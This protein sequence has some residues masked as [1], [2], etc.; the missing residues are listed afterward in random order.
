M[1]LVVDDDKNIRLSLK[2]ILERNDY[3]VAL[4]EGPKEAMQIVRNTPAVELVLM[5]MNYSISTDG[6]EGL[7]LLKQVRDGHQDKQ[8]KSCDSAD[9]KF[10]YCRHLPIWHSR[11]RGPRCSYQC[12]RLDYGRKRYG[13]GT[14][15]RGY[16]PTEPTGQRAVCESEPW[17][18]LHVAVRE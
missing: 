5:D 12:A 10:T 11:Y 14:H 9:S 1:I 17:R 4:A 2:L 13:Q 8:C 15:R 16:S 18:Y 3:E 7:T 6:E